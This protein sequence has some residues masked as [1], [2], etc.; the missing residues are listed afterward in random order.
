MNITN[1]S[2]SLGKPGV[3]IAEQVIPPPPTVHPAFNQATSS[4]I[5][6]PTSE[7]CI[8]YH[9]EHSGNDRFLHY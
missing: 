4:P 3:A 1:Q 5:P 9:H 6:N 2:G 8:F 7:K